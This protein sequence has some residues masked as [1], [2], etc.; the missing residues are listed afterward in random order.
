[1]IHK[2]QAATDYEFSGTYASVG[3]FVPNIWY[4]ILGEIGYLQETWG[5]PTGFSIAIG[6]NIQGNFFYIQ[7]ITPWGSYYQTYPNSY[8]NGAAVRAVMTGA[9]LT[10]NP[11][12]TWSLT[13]TGLT[14][15]AKSQ[16]INNGVEYTI[17]TIPG[18]TTNGTN[19][20]ERL[21][22]TYLAAQLP[23][24]MGPGDGGV[25]SVIGIGSWLDSCSITGGYHYKVSGTYQADSV[26]FD[27]SSTP[28]TCACFYGLY[29]W[30]TLPDSFH[31]GVASQVSATKTQSGTTAFTCQCN[32]FGQ[33]NEYGYYGSATSD[34]YQ[35][36][37]TISIKDKNTPVG[38]QTLTTSWGCSDNINGVVTGTS[39]GGAVTT[40]PPFT[41]CASSRSVAHKHENETNGCLTNVTHDPSCKQI[42]SPCGVCFSCSYEL[43]TFGASTKLSW[44]TAPTCSPVGKLHT[45]RSHHSNIFFTVDTLPGNISLWQYDLTGYLNNTIPNIYV[46]S[47]NALDSAQVAWRNDFTL[48]V[49]FSEGGQVKIISSYSYG[50]AGTWSTPF[51]I[52]AGTLPAFAI[53]L[54]NSLNYVAVYTPGSGQWTCWRHALGD[55][56]GLGTGTPNWV[57]AGNIVVSSLAV[58]AGLEVGTDAQQSLFFVYVDSNGNVQRL[59]SVSQG[60]YWET[61]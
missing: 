26:A 3:P 58:S 21:N 30:G 45:C 38:Q 36:D 41:T 14:F 47:G 35:S 54:K 51:V 10:V 50:A 44:S 53:D 59:K 4:N 46:S 33:G 17:L 48:H 18:T 24:S 7:V 2:N 15:Y 19:Y 32:N 60:A 49:V 1:M 43:C 39:G 56:E 22:I 5:V 20:D 42:E 6:N 9:A 31:V 57:N 23:R 8:Y 61:A 29:G 37:N 34:V 28:G 12:C 13:F 52:T 27:N 16:Y 55:G 40:T 25:C 11:D